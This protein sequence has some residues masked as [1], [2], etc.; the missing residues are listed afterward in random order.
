MSMFSAKKGHYISFIT[1]KS[2]KMLMFFGKIIFLT[3]V[4]LKFYQKSNSSPKINIFSTISRKYF[5]KKSKNNN[6]W[7]KHVL[8]CFLL[9][10]KI[11]FKKNDNFL[12]NFIPSK[13]IKNS[14][15]CRKQIYILKLRNFVI[16]LT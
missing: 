12:F 2:E 11:S 1:N 14:R 15:F 10:Y 8:T 16:F 4:V 13:L 3:G 9:H 7:T 6:F 5:V